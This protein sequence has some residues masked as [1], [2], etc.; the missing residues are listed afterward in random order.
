METIMLQG[1][2]KAEMKIFISLAQRMGIKA[3]FMTPS[4]VED[5]SL[6]NAMENGRTGEFVNTQQFMENL[7]KK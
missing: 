1:K 6:A 4:E 3:K 5:I 2:T 7:L